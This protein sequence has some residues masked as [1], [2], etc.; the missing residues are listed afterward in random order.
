MLVKVSELVRSVHK[1]ASDA[2]ASKPAAAQP[3]APAGKSARVTDTKE[4]LHT[5][6][7]DSSEEFASVV[8]RLKEVYDFV[9]SDAFENAPEELRAEQSKELLAF[10][11]KVA[12]LGRQLSP[13]EGSAIDE[14]T[15]PLVKL[16]EHVSGARIVAAQT[17]QTSPQ[18]KTAPPAQAAP[19]AARNGPSREF[20]T[21]V[22]SLQQV[23]GVVNSER[24]QAAPPQAQRDIATKLQSHVAAMVPHFKELA[25]DERLTVLKFVEPLLNLL[26]ALLRQDA[27]APP[28][29]QEAEETEED[30]QDQVDEEDSPED[31][32]GAFVMKLR[33]LMQVI[34]SDNFVKAPR[35]RRLKVAAML[36]QEISTLQQELQTL[37]PAQRQQVQPTFTQ[38]VA[39]IRQEVSPVEEEE[40]EQ[41]A[42]AAAPFSE[43]DEEDSESTEGEPEELDERQ[44]RFRAALEGIRL[45]RT[46]ILTFDELQ[47]QLNLLDEID[48]CGIS[49]QEEIKIRSVFHKELEQAIVKVK[50]ANGIPVDDDDEEGEGE[51]QETFRWLRYFIPR[52]D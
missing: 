52:R 24:F 4:N 6:A 40:E 43:N 23:F 41:S 39:L 49:S 44:T 18:K 32:F 27:P 11:N 12:A 51:E 25:E 45:M 22:E 14:L 50:V 31:Q 36:L 48:G 33:S 35:Q 28:V 34:G 10:V 1:H 29:E 20:T 16:L 26:Q 17:P 13:S 30:A 42:E 2:V 21:I 5:L 15:S 8:A 38:L 46:R 19:A 3:T 9:S 37:T 7:K 47:D